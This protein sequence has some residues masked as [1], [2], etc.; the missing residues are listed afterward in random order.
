MLLLGLLGQLLSLLI[1]VCICYTCRKIE[2]IREE[3]AQLRAEKRAEAIVEQDLM[4]YSCERKVAEETAKRGMGASPHATIF[5][6][7]SC[8]IPFNLFRAGDQTGILWENL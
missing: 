7:D 4:K 5:A 2:K 3:T 1:M 8:S 6:K